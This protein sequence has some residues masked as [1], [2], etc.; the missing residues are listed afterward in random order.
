[1]FDAINNYQSYGADVIDGTFVSTMF[2]DLSQ[3]VVSIPRSIGLHDIHSSKLINIPVT[4]DPTDTEPTKHNQSE[5][6]TDIID[7]CFSEAAAKVAT[8]EL[9]V[10]LVHSLLNDRVEGVGMSQSM[11]STYKMQKTPLRGAWS[12]IKK[13]F[14][15]LSGR[16]TK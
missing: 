15:S 8:D 14:S 6:V 13:A 16:S 10:P 5:S 9:G 4:S 11:C 12:R 7:Y 2:H 3:T 1:M